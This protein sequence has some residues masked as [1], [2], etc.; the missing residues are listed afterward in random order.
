MTKLRTRDTAALAFGAVPLLFAL[1]CGTP[2]ATIPPPEIEPPPAAQHPLRVAV[3]PLVDARIDAE[4]PDER[5]NYVY[6]GEL[7]RGTNLD[8]LRPT[9]MDHFT[10]RFAEALLRGGVFSEIVLVRS[11][12]DAPRADLVLSGAVL[13]ARGYVQRDPPEDEAPWVLGEVVLDRIELH[14]A[15]TGAVRFAGGTGWSIWASRSLPVDPWSVLAEALDRSVAEL[16]S[17]LADADLRDFEVAQSVSIADAIEPGVPP[18]QA[19]PPG[20]RHAVTSTESTPRGWRG[21]AD[22]RTETFTQRQSLRFH[23]LLGPYRPEVVVWICPATARLRWSPRTELPAV[24]MGADSD[25]RWVFGSAL[26]QTNWPA[27]LEQ[28]GRALGVTPPR[29]PYVIEIAAGAVRVAEPVEAPARPRRDEAPDAT[30]RSRVPLRPD[31]S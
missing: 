10:R 13:R 14:D 27:S 21:D 22:C 19:T 26:G 5:G 6:R 30:E 31:D 8:W 12:D 1:G 3:L 2:R 25:G 28:L 9:P 7:Y 11:V 4:A 23:R 29:S 20:W 16:A 18:A 15:E 17:V 24:L